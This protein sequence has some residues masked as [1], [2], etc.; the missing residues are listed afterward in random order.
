MMET[1]IRP[2]LISGTSWKSLPEA[3]VKVSKANPSKKR[4]FELEKG[5][6]YVSKPPLQVRG[7]TSYLTFAVLLPNK[8]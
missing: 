7:H 8:K 1:L 4:T 6:L 5:D 2:Q 3:G